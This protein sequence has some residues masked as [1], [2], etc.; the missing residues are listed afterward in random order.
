[1]PWAIYSPLFILPVFLLVIAIFRLRVSRPM[2]GQFNVAIVLLAVSMIF[3]SLIVFFEIPSHGVA[4]VFLSNLLG[5]L[6][7]IFF[8]LG[9][10]RLAWINRMPDPEATIPA[11]EERFPERPD[12]GPP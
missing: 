12:L 7:W 5:A 6:A 9:C 10:L 4:L 11:D 2:I 3:S 8:G 1:M